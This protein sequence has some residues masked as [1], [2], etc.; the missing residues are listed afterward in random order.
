MRVYE[1]V[2]VF[3]AVRKFEIVRFE[4]VRVQLS[5]NQTARLPFYGVKWHFSKGYDTKK[6]HCNALEL[7]RVTGH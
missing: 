1:S 7:L 5:A 4:D 2:R 3:D 6:K